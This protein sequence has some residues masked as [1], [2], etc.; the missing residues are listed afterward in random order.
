[1]LL[2][3]AA[4][5]LW[6]YA[7]ANPRSYVVFIAVGILVGRSVLGRISANDQIDLLAKFGNTLLL[8]V[9][10]LKLDQQIIRIIRLDFVRQ[11]LQEA[12]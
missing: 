3:T 11:P 2:F 8:F 4:V 5:G 1:M 12:Q 6:A 7:C 10:G 9:V